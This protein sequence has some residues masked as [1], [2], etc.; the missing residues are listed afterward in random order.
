L[1]HDVVL[2]NSR[3]LGVVAVQSVQDG[4]N[5]L[6]P[7]GRVVEGDTHVVC[8]W[9]LV[10]VI[11]DGVKILC[12]LLTTSDG[13]P[14]L[15]RLS[16]PWRSVVS[17]SV[18]GQLT[19]INDHQLDYSA[20]E[21]SSYSRA[22]AEASD[23]QIWMQSL[24]MPRGRPKTPYNT[25]KL[26]IPCRNTIKPKMGTEN[27]PPSV[28]VTKQAICSSIIVAAS[29]LVSVSCHPTSSSTSRATSCCPTMLPASCACVQ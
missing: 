17:S 23:Y 2:E 28:L 16:R 18:G 22:N 13:Q 9:S 26:S 24:S 11:L 20:C 4:I 21:G 27:D 7:L 3:G 8:D 14:K 1:R 6:W 25:P 19:Y 5:V 12:V 29:C 15:L 10:Y